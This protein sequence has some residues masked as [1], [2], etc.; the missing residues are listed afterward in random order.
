MADTPVWMANGT[1]KPISAVHTN[2]LVRTGLDTAKVAVVR[3]LHQLAAS[4]FTELRLAHGLRP[5]SA[6]LRVTSEHLI[7]VDG[8]GWVLAAK[9]M[10]GDWL[11]DNQGHRVEVLGSQVI[12]QKAEVYTLSLSGDNVFYADGVLVHDLCGVQAA[13]A[14][15]V[16]LGVA[17]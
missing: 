12:K 15:T 9:V 14:R 6:R 10:P 5:G 13:G 11:L 16:N 2:E 8:K 7:W 17:K 3:G 4:E 1:W